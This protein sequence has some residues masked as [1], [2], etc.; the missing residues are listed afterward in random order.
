MSAPLTARVVRLQWR[1]TLCR[2]R[3]DT[4]GRAHDDPDDVRAAAGEALEPFDDRHERRL[5][6]LDESAALVEPA[7]ATP[8][9]LVLL[10]PFRLTNQ[11]APSHTQRP[12]APL[13]DRRTSEA[14]R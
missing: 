12:A 10:R 3:F 8:S 1:W 14:G 2:R 13:A 7:G 4:V 5:D 9:C 11:P 6:S